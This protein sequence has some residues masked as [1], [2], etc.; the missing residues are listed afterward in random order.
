VTKPSGIQ[1]ERHDGAATVTL[2]EPGT[3]N[4]ISF[5]TWRALADVFRE[6]DRDQ[7]VRGV[8]LTGQGEAF[9][10]GADIGDFEQTR[11]TPEQVAT[12]EAQVDE[13]CDT[14]AALGKPVVAAIRGYCLGGACNL[15]MACDFRFVA[16]DVIV[17]I[18]AA[19]LSIVYS[20]RGMARLASL[21]G[22]AE[23]KR[24]MFGAGRFGADHALKCG[25]AD[26]VEA[27]PAAAA[28]TYLA[29]LAQL[30]PLSI[31]G[32]KM[33]LNSLAL[34]EFSPA[35][36]AAA[37][38]RAARSADYAEGRAAFAEKRPPRFTGA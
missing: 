21:V 27:D 13:T 10:S 26:R 12:Y 1:V 37:A 7:G 25:F 8:I 6:L 29:E 32:S 16:D 24:I 30:A 31:S 5:A 23:A 33:V 19:R 20:G 15:A 4:P 9:S 34:G 28:R 18:P 22:T 38:D 11:A 14:L 17:G 2:G 3:F 35:A 36:A